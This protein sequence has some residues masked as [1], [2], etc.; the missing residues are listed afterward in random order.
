MSSVERINLS[1]SFAAPATCEPAPTPKNP[2]AALPRERNTLVRFRAENQPA[3]LAADPVEAMKR[4]EEAI[5]I[6]KEGDRYEIASEALQKALD[7]LDQAIAL[8]P[9]CVGA[10]LLRGCTYAGLGKAKKGLED[11]NRGIQI[12]PDYTDK[13]FSQGK[14]YFFRAHLKFFIKMME[15]FESS[16]EDFE[17]AVSMG[18]QEAK[19]FLEMITTGPRYFI[20]MLFEQEQE[21][22]PEYSF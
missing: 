5:Q 15:T 21:K 11:F 6:L 17:K 2:S 18:N 19:E 1:T 16:I 10:Y 3:T 7:K 4:Y 14:A 9:Q 8:D 13:Y 12:N 20:G 22:D